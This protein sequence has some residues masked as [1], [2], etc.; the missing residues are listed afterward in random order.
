MAPEQL[1]ERGD[2][3]VAQVLM[4]DRVELAVVDQID[5]IGHLQD[6]DA[7]LFEQGRDALDQAVEVGDVGQHVV[8]DD[9]VGA[10]ALGLE[11]GRDLATE[12]LVEGRDPGADRGRRRRLGRIDALDRDAA[13]DEVAQKVA[14]VARDLDH[15]GARAQ[16]LALD[17]LER[18][19]ARVRQEGARDRG[20]VR[21]VAAEQDLGADR[22]GDLNQRAGAAEADRQRHLDLG[23]LELLGGQQAVGERGL[24]ERQDG[25]QIGAAAGAAAGLGAIDVHGSPR[26]PQSAAASSVQRRSGASR[27]S[28]RSLRRNAIRL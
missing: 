5:Q 7:V 20:E 2:R 9:H 4:V 25:G 27:S 23:R 8:G 10:P 1:V 12:E 21:V 22:L 13:L 3:E 19:G 28:A 14:V 26:L 16:P 15:Q 6:R 24:P 17:Q 18:V 11:P